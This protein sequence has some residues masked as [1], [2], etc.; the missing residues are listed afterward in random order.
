MKLILFSPSIV[1]AP[2]KCP[3]LVVAIN[4]LSPKPV[5]PEMG[6]DGPNPLTFMPYLPIKIAIKLQPII[7]RDFCKDHSVVLGSRLSKVYMFI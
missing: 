4:S 2:N 7:I 1:P 6:I 5:I 3:K